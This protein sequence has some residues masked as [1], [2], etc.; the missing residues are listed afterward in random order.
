MNKARTL[1]VCA[2][3]AI[4]LTVTACSTRT[5]NNAESAFN[6]YGKS[7]AELGSALTGGEVTSVELVDYY[8]ERIHKFDE[9]GPS[10]NS[11]IALNPSARPT[12]EELDAR[13]L[14]FR[15]HVQR[16]RTGA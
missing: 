1:L 9:Q 13:W 16:P 7:V 4:A 14:S 6:P 8:T 2:V 15:R 12:A 3:T 10:I 11:I 5:D